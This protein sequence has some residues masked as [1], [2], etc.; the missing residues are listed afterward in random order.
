[1]AVLTCALLAA[2]YLCAD[3]ARDQ[4]ASLATAFARRATISGLASG[5]VACVGIAVL[6]ADAPELFHGLTHRALPLVI[7]SIVAGL[8]GPALLNKRRY[9]AARPAAAL[10]VA[11]IL[12]AWGA[13]QY[14]AMLVGSTTVGQAAS[15]R[16]VLAAC[17]IALAVGAVLLVPSLWLLY[18]TFQRRVPTTSEA[19]G[20]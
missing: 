6:H 17:L 2:V 16:G 3:A 1:M 11:A 18:A 20:D 9:I 14:P 7:L 8:T 4:K 19:R 12:W 15:H 5:A 13:G 10:A